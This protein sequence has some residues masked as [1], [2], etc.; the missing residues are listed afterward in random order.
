MAQ[1][2]TDKIGN[3]ISKYNEY[4]YFNGCA[5]VAD[6][7]QIIFEKGY[8]FANMEWGIQNEPDTKF[9]IGSITKQFT[10]MLVMQ[11]VEQGKIKL[12]GKITDYLPYYRKDTG[13]QI[14]IEMLL[15]HTSGIPSYTSREDF[16]EKISRNHFSPDDFIKEYCSGDLEFKPGAEFLYNNSGYFILGSIIEHVTGLT[17]ADVLN[18]NIL[19]PLNLENTGYDL[20]EIVLP[21][22]ATGYEKTFN[23]YS[24]AAFLDMSLP[25]AAGSLYST[26]E[27]LFKWDMALQ[28]N[29]LLSQIYM[30]ELFKPRVDAFGEKYGF[31]WIIGKKEIDS[32][33]YI[34]HTHGGGINGFNTINYIIPLKGQV[35]I[36]FSNAGEAPLNEMTNEIINIL[37]NK[38]FK[39][40]AQPL[41][42]KM[43]DIIKENGIEAAINQFKELKDKKDLYVFS[44]QEINRLG[45]ELMNEKKLDDALLIFKLNIDEFPKSW[46]VYDSY[47]EALL[48]KGLR[49]EAIMNYKKSLELNP[50]NQSGI[51]ALTD[52][53]AAIDI[54]EPKEVKL[55]EE[56]L[57]HY[58]GKYQLAPNFILTITVNNDKIF[59]QATG[60][61]QLEIFPSSEDEFYLKVVD[62]RIKFVTENGVVTKLILFQNGKEMPAVKIE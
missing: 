16:S 52:L 7:N 56:V 44:E 23:G 55:S 27:D 24:T 43:Y 45:Y 48:K 37:N 8:G 42:N 10:S 3:L 41:V 60:Q 20:Y 12:D 22:R 4:R 19:Q 30:D 53:G 6:K 17:Y 26:V 9:R 18:K 1:T 32:T 5:L 50:R 29:K 40:P 25:Y 57:N 58:V 36:L 61:S 21:K 39:L 28:T 46:N 11:L 13:D 31:G 38:E 59:A 35:V 34:V 14:T 15:T 54:D 49:D 47:G 33:E 2:I 62:A 51:K